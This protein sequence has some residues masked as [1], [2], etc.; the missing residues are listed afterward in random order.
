MSRHRQVGRLDEQPRGLGALGAGQRER[1]RAQLGEQL[2]LDLAGAVAEPGGQARH[3]LAV[4][5]AVGD[6]P[7]GA[8]HEIGA[9]RSTRGEPGL[10]SGRQRLQARNPACWQAAALG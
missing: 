5:H 4:H 7:H 8:R 6:Q 1:A 2:A 3:A 10:V 9:L